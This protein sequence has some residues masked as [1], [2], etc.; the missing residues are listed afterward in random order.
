MTEYA[1]LRDKLDE[2]VLAQAKERGL[3]I[4]GEMHGSAIVLPRRGGGR[5]V[6]ICERCTWPIGD[7][8]GAPSGR[9]IEVELDESKVLE[10][11][12]HM[13]ASIHALHGPGNVWQLGGGL[14][15]LVNDDGMWRYRDDRSDRML[16]RLRSY[17]A[18]EG[19]AQS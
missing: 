10:A 11:A 6:E 2:H 12:T 13:V 1:K 8:E 18:H 14:V 19:D 3:T 15:H 16:V 9:F 17:H 7:Y 5:R 4:A